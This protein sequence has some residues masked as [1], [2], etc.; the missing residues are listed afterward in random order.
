MPI[1]DPPLLFVGVVEAPASEGERLRARFYTVDS[2]SGPVFV[3]FAS[4]DLAAAI[5]SLY[6][7]A[8]GVRFA[9]ETELPEEMTAGLTT[10]PVVFIH[11][12]N[13]Y[14]LLTSRPAE[15][16]WADRTVLYDFTDRTS[17]LPPGA[18]P[19]P[20]TLELAY[21]MHPERHWDEIYRTHPPTELSWHQSYPTLSM[22]Y[23]T[24]FN[25]PRG[26]PIIDVGGG[27]SLLPDALLEAGYDDVT[28]LDVSS[29]ALEHA[30]A[31]LGE[32]AARVQ[33]IEGH[34]LGTDL[35]R[36]AFSVWHDRA[37]FHFLRSRD[38]RSQYLS[39][40]RH[41]LRPGGHVVIGTFHDQGPKRCSGLDVVRY[42]TSSL[43]DVFGDGFTLVSSELEQHHTPAG[44]TQLFVWCVLRKLEPGHTA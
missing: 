27:A 35:P 41:A 34:M 31:R 19:H 1:S 18:T 33:W 32:Q 3:A 38:E 39:Q 11:T 25:P 16:P 29:V 10:H 23:I 30:R 14:T 13:D 36:E 8:A 43:V 9:V 20:K 2:P 44:T 6:G 37:V 7:M 15:F 21:V 42:D 5:A 12:M 22:E 40:V 17:A 28:V 26:G 4:H 24:R